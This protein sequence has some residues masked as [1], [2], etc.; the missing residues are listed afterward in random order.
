MAVWTTALGTESVPGFITA[1]A[2]IVEL[3]TS[4]MLI[5]PAVGLST[6]VV[7][8]E[9][10]ACRM[11]R[12]ELLGYGIAL[13][14]CLLHFKG[15]VVSGFLTYSWGSVTRPGPLH[16]LV[17]T[18]AVVWA[19]LGSFVCIQAL[20]RSPDPSVRIRAKYWLLGV[21]VFFPTVLV[22]FLANYGVPVFPVGSIG[23]ILMVGIFTYAAVRHRLMDIDL[24][25]M[26]AAATLMASVVV[27]LPIAGAAI[28][29]QRLPAGGS[30][31][32]VIGCL[33]LAALLSLLVFSRVRSYLELEVESALFRSRHAAREAI[34]QLSAELVK[35]PASGDGGRHLTQTLMDGLGLQGVALY[36]QK[37]TG[38]YQLGCACGTI[39]AP[40]LLNR[41]A[42][43]G[44]YGGAGDVQ[45]ER[46]D[47]C[48]PVRTS[49]AELGYLALGAKRSG[50]AI[51]DSDLA[52]L[53]LVASQ[54]AVGLKNAEY[55]RE[56][57]RQQTQIEELRARLEAE[58]VALR[59]EV[60]AASQF[61]EII[62]SSGALQRVL[63]LVEK[64]APS[65]TSVLITGETGT[66][67]E[68][69]ARAL[70]ELSPR[71]GGP[72]ISV[73]CPAIPPELAESELF[74]HERG[75]FTGALAA[76]P[77]KF[78][79]ADKG[80]IFLDEV[81]DLPMSVQVKL[82]RVLQEHETQRVGACKVRKL[83]LRV[84]AASNRDLE[85]EM[86]AQRFREDLY[87]R[88]AAVRVEVPALRERLEDVPM[89]ASFFLERA[90]RVHQ[91]PITGF[92]AEAL[93]ALGRYSWPGNIREL[94]NVIERAVL[95]CT[96]E[97]IRPEHLSD[98]AV[99]AASAAGLGASLREEKRRRIEQA[100]AQ[101]GG[102]QAAAARLL[103]I[104]PSNLAR[105][106]KS[107]GSKRPPA[108]H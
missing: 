8:S 28:W 94:Q 31:A 55:V 75:A 61:S 52:L 27:V 7:W 16:P 89:L 12:L 74:G 35:L 63:A 34:R 58:N 19:G 104:S 50:A 67:K 93:A 78:E 76:R 40:K 6:A 90:A 20:K 36:L 44:A 45:P 99:G 72:L 77:G 24:F 96:G 65:A 2:A 85:R 100:L 62:G 32:L 70:H 46:W 33:L 84:V 95:L 5:L 49:G 41:R 101:T 82:L 60:R 87:Y 68:L 56:I 54:L 26:R 107:L 51:D 69:I 43:D 18:F 39:A 97:V 98:L 17:V 9:T 48:V 73:N 37:K 66:G 3:L 21:A 105:L 81:A 83:D 91:R 80:T 79:L 42:F 47:A 53:T 103:G 108:V 30:S 38:V 92:T 14:L 102:N 22:N 15:F 71:R 10:R 4:A 23:N 1:H 59:S 106:I 29:G 64:V 11:K 13:L 88:L 25:I 57:R 86:R